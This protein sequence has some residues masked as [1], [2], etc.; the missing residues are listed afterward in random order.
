MV[1][2]CTLVDT[3]PALKFVPEK[4]SEG[5]PSIAARV[6]RASTS[7]SELLAFAMFSE[8]DRA[9]MVTARVIAVLAVFY[10]VIIEINIQILNWLILPRVLADLRNAPIRTQEAADRMRAGNLRLYRAGQGKAQRKERGIKGFR[11]RHCRS[12]GWPPY[13]APL[14]GRRSASELIPA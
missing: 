13:R 2:P 10:F 9:G 7:F 1:P 12:S 14:G 5:R 11:S 6:G 3:K 8:Y 4:N